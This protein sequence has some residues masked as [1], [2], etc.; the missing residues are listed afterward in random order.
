MN[1]AIIGRKLGM[2]QYFTPEG[3]MIPVTVIEAGP[4]PVVQ[5]KTVENDGYSA[6]QLGFGE[7]K[8]QNVNKPRA[9]A[10][11]KAGVKP[12][13]ILREFK[14]DDAEKYEVGSS[15]TAG[16]FAAGDAVDVSGVSRGRGFTG[17]VQRWN[18]HMIFKTH[19]AGPVHRHL[20]AMSANTGPSRVFP[21]KKMPGHYGAEKV[22][23]Q[24]LKVVKVDTER[25]VLL[26]K[27]AVPGP[28]GGFVTVRSAVK[29]QK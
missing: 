3:L 16:A 19:G 4:C 9:G 17:V 22:T 26:V 2:S 23:V 28:K 8:E 13:R 24:N 18:H 12:A 15:V 14:L 20:G 10:F 29:T 5:V 6:V 1:K 7:I 21:G 27:G 11:K 25:N